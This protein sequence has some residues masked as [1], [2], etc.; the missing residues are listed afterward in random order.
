M[1]KEEISLRSRK[2]IQSYF[3]RA[4]QLRFSASVKHCVL[5]AVAWLSRVTEDI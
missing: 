5:C 4:S 3:Q 1:N 2:C